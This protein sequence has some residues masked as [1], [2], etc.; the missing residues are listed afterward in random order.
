MGNIRLLVCV[1]IIILSSGSR[2]R[3]WYVATYRI[4]CGVVM[5]I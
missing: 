2:M 3:M 5:E 1:Y 4:E